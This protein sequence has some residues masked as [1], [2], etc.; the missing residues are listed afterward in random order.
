MYRTFG[1]LQPLR[2]DLDLDLLQA[3]LVSSIRNQQKK[4]KL[5]TK[6]FLPKVYVSTTELS[7]S[8]KLNSRR[9][10]GIIITRGF[11]FRFSILGLDFLCSLA[12]DF[13]YFF[14]TRR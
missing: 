7:Q 4:K 2:A 6:N 10:F 12:N 8:I 5:E 11:P 9:H 1:P 13:L 3:E 14:D